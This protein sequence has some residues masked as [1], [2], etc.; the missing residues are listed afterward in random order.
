M[1]LWALAGSLAGI[2]IT[3]GTLAARRYATR[4]VVPIRP[5]SAAE[6][7]AQAL[8]RMEGE[9]GPVPAK[10]DPRLD[11]FSPSRRSGIERRKAVTP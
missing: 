5:L 4:R 3:A 2:V 7:E 6:Q 11:V 10:R 1:P 9:G 8:A